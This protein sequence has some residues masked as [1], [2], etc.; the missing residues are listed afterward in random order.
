MPEENVRADRLGGRATRRNIGGRDLTGEGDIDYKYI[1]ADNHIDLVWYPHDIIQSRIE[2][3]F[4]EKAPK[5]VESPQG[6]S[7]AVGRR[8]PRVRR[9]RQGL[10]DSRQAVP[11]HRGRGG[12][13]AAVR[14]GDTAPSHGHRRVL[15][16]R[17]LRK[18]AQVGVQ[19]Q[20]AGEGGLPGVQRLGGGAVLLLAGPADRAAVAARSL[21]RDVRC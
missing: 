2:P 21:P 16:G 1:S 12:P 18:H 10:G 15:R 19:G 4:R 17:L 14:P 3:E 11:A 13:A 8:H 6:H 7:V 20:G 5:V 9:R